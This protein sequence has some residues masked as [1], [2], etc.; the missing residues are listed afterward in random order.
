MMTHGLSWIPGIVEFADTA[1]FAASQT[2]SVMRNVPLP[3]GGDATD[4]GAKIET[5]NAIRITTA[6]VFIWLL[7]LGMLF[8]LSTSN[9]N[10]KVGRREDVQGFPCLSCRC[11]GPLCLVSLRTKKTTPSAITIQET[12]MIIVIHVP[13]PGPSSMW[14]GRPPW[15]YAAEAAHR[16]D[17]AMAAASLFLLAKTIF[18][19]V[20]GRPDKFMP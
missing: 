8:Y 19:P 14:P 9:Y 2:S 6:L 18:L 3:V 16:S 12:T 11:P 4:N 1:G 5:A 7:F 20:F 10:Y 17:A 15:A 13:G